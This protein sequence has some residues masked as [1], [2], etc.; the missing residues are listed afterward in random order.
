MAASTIGSRW[1]TSK[2][3]W[4]GQFGHVV[5]AAVRG[6]E[7]DQAGEAADACWWQRVG[8]WVAWSVVAAMAPAGVSSRPV[9]MA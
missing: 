2:D 3:S 1:S 4:S 7:F 6:D 8:Q 9:M 5:A